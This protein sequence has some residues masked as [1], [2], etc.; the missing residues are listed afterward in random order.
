MSATTCLLR[1]VYLS[2]AAQYLEDS[3][4]NH[5]GVNSIAGIWVSSDDLTVLPEIRRLATTFFPNV[6]MRQRGHNILQRQRERPYE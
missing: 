2:A 6:Q 5:P 4:E 1:Q 3:P